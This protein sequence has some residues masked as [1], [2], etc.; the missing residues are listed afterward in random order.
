MASSYTESLI[1]AV[2]ARSPALQPILDIKI[3]FLSYLLCYQ[4]L[5]L[6]NTTLRNLYY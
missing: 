3:Q 1:K 5:L 2:E 4:L 6:W